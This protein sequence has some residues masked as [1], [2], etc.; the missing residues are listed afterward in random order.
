MLVTVPYSHYCSLFGQQSICLARS[1]CC[2]LRSFIA[3]AELN[4][5]IWKGI[6]VGRWCEPF[7][8]LSQIWR[9]FTDARCEQGAAWKHF[10]V[11]FQIISKQWC[12]HKGSA[13]FKGRQRSLCTWN[14]QAQSSL[15]SAQTKTTLC[16]SQ[17]CTI[18]KPTERRLDR[19]PVCR[20]RQSITLSNT[21]THSQ[22]T[23]T[24]RHTQTHTQNP[25]TN[26]LVWNG[27]PIPLWVL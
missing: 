1:V 19:Q 6:S 16:L 15:S 20:D 18:I 22:H 23:H 12:R 24:H 11:G 3:T 17:A 14:T 13:C 7:P 26:G 10:I 8:A 9:V 25:Q 21:C 27:N 2:C 4:C 5:G